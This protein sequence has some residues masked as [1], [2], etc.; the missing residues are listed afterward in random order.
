MQDK[1]PS[2]DWGWVKKE[3]FRIERISPYGKGSPEAVLAS[4]D[5]CIDLA[6]KLSKPKAITAVKKVSKLTPSG[7]E[8]TDGTCISS[9]S[10]PSHMNGAEEVIFFLVTLGCA[11]EDKSSKLMAE[12]DALDGYLLDRIGSIAVEALADAVETISREALVK[13]GKSLSMRFSPG[14]CGW[15]IEEQFKVAG[16]LDFSKAGVKL[17]DRCMMVPKKSISAACAIGP[18]KLFSAKKSHCTICELK[19][20]VYR[21]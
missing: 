18:K 2:I 16:I 12:G 9:P 13:N 19:E 21:R 1:R 17:T 14:Y 20:C 6:K 5:K 4:A 8:F 3:L 7:I 10:L 15:P 11:L